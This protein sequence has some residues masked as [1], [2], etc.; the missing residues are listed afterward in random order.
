[1]TSQIKRCSVSIP[2]NITEGYGRNYRKDYI[3]FLNIS[4]GFFI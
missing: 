3:R 1:M 4:R 2:S